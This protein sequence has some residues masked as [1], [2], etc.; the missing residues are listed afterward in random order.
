M[1]FVIRQNNKLFACFYEYFFCM[2]NDLYF[3]FYDDLK[4]CRYILKN[5]EFKNKKYL[6]KTMQPQRFQQH[7]RNISSPSSQQSGSFSQ[8]TVIN[9]ST[10]YQQFNQ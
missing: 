8:S 2:Q 1:S 3:D 9:K 6:N 7:V 5:I 4:N 10:S